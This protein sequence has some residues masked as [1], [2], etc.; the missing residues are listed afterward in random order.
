MDIVPVWILNVT[1]NV[2]SINRAAALTRFSDK[3]KMYGCFARTEKVSV[4]NEVPGLEGSEERNLVQ[5]LNSPF[6]PPHKGAEPGRA[7]EEK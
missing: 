4:F 7:K 5:S 2:D 3:K 6:F 1:V